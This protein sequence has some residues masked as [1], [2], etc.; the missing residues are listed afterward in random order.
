MLTAFL[1][2]EAPVIAAINGPALSHLE[3]AL[4][5]DVVLAA[6]H[7]VFGDPTHFVA[8]IPPGD[9]MHLV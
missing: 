1:E 5:S 9:E 2:I 8:G 3:L 4:L 7:T 6:D